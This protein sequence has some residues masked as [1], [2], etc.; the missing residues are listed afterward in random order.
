MIL[1]VEMFFSIFPNS[2]EEKFFKEAY[3]K[4]NLRETNAGRK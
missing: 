3:G 4:I 2:Y 1:S